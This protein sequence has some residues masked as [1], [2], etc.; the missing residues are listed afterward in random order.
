MGHLERRKLGCIFMLKNQNTS[1]FVKD[2]LCVLLVGL[3]EDNLI[4]HT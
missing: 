2:L 3:Q 1:F 4:H